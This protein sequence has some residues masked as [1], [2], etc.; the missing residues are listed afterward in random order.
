MNAKELT[1]EERAR[2]VYE[3]LKDLL[4]DLEEEDLGEFCKGGIAAC[5][6]IL[7]IVNPVTGHKFEGD[8]TEL[9]ELK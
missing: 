1:T 7:D 4:P 5:S 6:V 3:H 2:L 8:L 9:V